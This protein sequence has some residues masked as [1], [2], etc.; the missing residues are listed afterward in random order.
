MKHCSGRSPRIANPDNQG[1]DSVWHVVNSAF[2]GST[3]HSFDLGPGVSALIEGNVFNDVAQTSLHESSPGR[4]FAPSDKAVCSQCKGM[5]GRDCQPNAYIRANPIPSTTSAG[6]VLKGVVGEKMVK[7]LTPDQV[8]EQIGSTAGCNGATK[9]V[10]TGEVGGDQH[11]DYGLPPNKSGGGGGGDVASGGAGSGA[12]TDA[13]A[14]GAT[15]PYIAGQQA[16]P[17]GSPQPQLA[18]GNP[19]A[20]GSQPQSYGQPDAQQLKQAHE[21]QKKLAEQQQKEQEKQQKKQAEEH[22][23]QQKKQAEEQKKQQHKRE[24][25]EKKKQQQQGEQH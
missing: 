9:G 4:A 1:G 16:S 5:M 6:V 7:A 24:E 25:E 17:N 12:G 18:G 21:E 15:T 14:V 13:S 10:A 8:K 2:E 20:P 3:G 11:E 23:K 22:K 19:W